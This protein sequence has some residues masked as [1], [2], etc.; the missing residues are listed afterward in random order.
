MLCTGCVWHKRSLCIAGWRELQHAA[1][2][3]SVLRCVCYHV[4]TECTFEMHMYQA[5]Y[6]G[7]CNTLQC[8]AMSYRKCTACMQMYIAI[9]KHIQ[10]AATHCNEHTVTHGNTLQC[11]AGCR[12]GVSTSALHVS[13]TT[14]V[15]RN[16]F[17]TLQHTAT[18]PWTHCNTLQCAAM[19]CNE[20]P[21]V[22]WMYAKVHMY[23]K[24]KKTGR[25]YTL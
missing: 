15:S 22:Q 9:E 10:D 11:V 1:T 19:C 18:L 16:I 2:H 3:C 5:T 7:R 14:Y 13:R 6:T 20:L 4:C 24:K 21:Q 8:V 12:N 17:Q 23:R 25:C